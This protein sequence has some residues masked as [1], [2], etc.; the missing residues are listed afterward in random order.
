MSF[1][2]HEGEVV[3]QLLDHIRRGAEFYDKPGFAC[4]DTDWRVYSSTLQ[5]IINQLYMKY[6]EMLFYE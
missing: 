5:M 6:K 3:R 2:V 1:G 4:V